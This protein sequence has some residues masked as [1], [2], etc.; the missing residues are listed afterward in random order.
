MHVQLSGVDFRR[1]F[2][3][4]FSSTH[5]GGDGSGT[6]HTAPGMHAKVH[7]SSLDVYMETFFVWVY[8]C[9]VGAMIAYRPRHTRM[10]RPASLVSALRR[11]IIALRTPSRHRRHRYTS[12]PL[13][14]YFNLP[15]HHYPRL[16]RVFDQY[17]VTIPRQCQ[18]S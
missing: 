3:D 9:F 12:H 5:F 1:G 16:P 8:C 14:Y 6:L 4:T 17:R 10:A 7:V 15:Y 13:E 18:A 11:T 2:R